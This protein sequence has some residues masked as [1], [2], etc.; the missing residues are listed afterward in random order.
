VQ[1]RLSDRNLEYTIHSAC[2]N[3]GRTIEI[4]VDSELNIGRVTDGARPMYSMAIM[5]TETMTEKSIIDV[6]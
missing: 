2:A 6:F 3:S 4:E 5:N 1:G